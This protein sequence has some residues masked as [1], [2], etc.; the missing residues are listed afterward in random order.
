MYMSSNSYLDNQW[1]NVCDRKTEMWYNPNN[2]SVS[3]YSSY[4][5]FLSSHL[6][7]L[8]NPSRFL[9]LLILAGCRSGLLRVADSS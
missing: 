1:G 8:L 4:H 2:S 3:V 6:I 9:K 5:N 7:L